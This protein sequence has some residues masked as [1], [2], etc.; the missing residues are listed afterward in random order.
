MSTFTCVECLNS[1]QKNACGITQC[2]WEIAQAEGFHISSLRSAS[3]S[4]EHTPTV[5]SEHL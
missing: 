3:I 2:L 4:Q 1:F 5:V